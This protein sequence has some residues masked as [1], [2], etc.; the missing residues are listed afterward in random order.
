MILVFS[1]TCHASDNIKNKLCFFYKRKTT[2]NF[3]EL[4]KSG[5]LF[6]DASRSIIQQAG[7]L[8]QRNS[9]SYN[10]VRHDGA[11]FSLKPLMRLWVL[12]KK[13]KQKKP[14]K[15]FARCS[16]AWGSGTCALTQNSGHH[17]GKSP[18]TSLY[19]SCALAKL[20]LE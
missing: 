3:E 4:N 13:E 16:L 18:I 7:N 1:G 14:W 11:G 5:P 17:T 9:G 6:Y 12:F 10:T 8:M 15:L 2:I 19:L 20:S